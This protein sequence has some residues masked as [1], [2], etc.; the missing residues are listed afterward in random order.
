ML[1]IATPRLANPKDI[2]NLVDLQFPSG[3]SGC[4][5]EV[6]AST[7]LLILFNDLHTFTRG[8]WDSGDYYFSFLNLRSTVMFQ[9]ALLDL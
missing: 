9:F 1:P 5:R 3:A 7:T 2:I 8:L 6:A 4:F